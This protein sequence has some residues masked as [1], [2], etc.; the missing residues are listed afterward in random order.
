MISQASSEHSICLVLD[1]N[2][3]DRS[4]AA[5]QSELLR[6]WQKLKLAVFFI[7]HNVEEAIFLSQRIVLMSPHPGQVQEI[8]R[9]DL[10]YPR[11][12]G[13]TE[14]GA[15]YARITAALHS[16]RSDTSQEDTV[17]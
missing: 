11:D 9:V 8:I 6:I 16:Q 10:P 2:E 15:L 1:A 17:Q 4:L 13:S 7:T 3:A 5:L 12:R 14:F